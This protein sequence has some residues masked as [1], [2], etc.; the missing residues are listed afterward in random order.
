[1]DDLA[2]EEADNNRPDTH[3]GD[4]QADRQ[5]G[6]DDRG[7]HVDQDLLLELE[8]SLHH[9]LR[10]LDQTLGEEAQRHDGEDRRL[11]GRPEQR[12]D[13]G[14]EEQSD[15]GQPDGDGE[16]EKEG[17]VDQV[18]DALLLVVDDVR[19]DAEVQQDLEVRD[20]RERGG[21]HAEGLRIEEAGQDERGDEAGEAGAPE[22][23]DL[24]GEA[25]HRGCP[26]AAGRSRRA[27]CDRVGER[28]GDS[29]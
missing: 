18:G 2:G 27:Q 17:G 15:D 12:G 13:G 24:P 7:P 1:M 19:T 4:G 20:E 8:V 22:G 9:R 26:E 21:E 6:P 28:R 14:R 11:V 10:D 3:P 23:E 5:P 16:V 29:A 25:L